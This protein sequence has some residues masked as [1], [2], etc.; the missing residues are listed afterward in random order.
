[1]TGIFELNGDRLTICVNFEG[2]RP[3]KFESPKG[4]EILLIVRKHEKK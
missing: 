3:D 1:M 2:E 4:S